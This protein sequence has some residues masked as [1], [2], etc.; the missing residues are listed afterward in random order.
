ME[1]LLIISHPTQDKGSKLGNR[2]SYPQVEIMKLRKPEFDL[3]FLTIIWV[4]YA[5]LMIYWIDIPDRSLSLFGMLLI[6]GIVSS[7]GIWMNVRLFGYIFAGV[8][9]VAAVLSVMVMLGYIV[10]DRPFSLRSLLTVAVL[11][12]CVYAGVRWAR[13]AWQALPSD[14]KQQLENVG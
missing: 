12:Y 7:I 9:L 1:F 11:L 2:G 14:S 6:C 4:I 13:S 5:A 3:G 10:P 8:N